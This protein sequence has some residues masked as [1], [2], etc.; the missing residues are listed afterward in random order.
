MSSHV[1]PEGAERTRERGFFSALTEALKNGHAARKL[2]EV[3]AAD[4]EAF[5]PVP[6]HAR[7]QAEREW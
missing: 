2:R 3:V 7:Q 1:S 6:D 5:G 4:R